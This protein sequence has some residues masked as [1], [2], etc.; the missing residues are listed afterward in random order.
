[1]KE[2][3]IIQS[4]SINTIA[5]VFGMI[6]MFIIVHLGFGAT[7]IKHFPEFN[8][9][10]WVHHIH[11]ALM[12]AWVLLLIVQ[13]LFIHY[14]KFALH[15]LLGKLS[16]VLAPLMIVS[17]LFVAKHNYEKSIPA[18]SA[19]DVMAVQ[20]ITWMQ[21]VLFTLFYSLAVYFRKNTYFHMRFMIGTAIVMLGP[22]MNRIL[23][24]YFSDIPVPTILLISLYIKTG[25]AAA[26][27]LNDLVKKKNSIP[28]LI[29][30]GAFLFSDIVYHLRYSDAWQAVGRFIV[31]I[32]Y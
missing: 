28:G 21:I 3:K 8:G 24:S 29:V 4:A 18:K 32:F 30:F 26:L 6:L 22:P 10:K 11:G 25:I 15:R 1:M 13:P 27:L 9:F 20:S 14:K 31:N 16:Y 17:M 2:E 7:Y 19:V 5:I 12:G 23:L